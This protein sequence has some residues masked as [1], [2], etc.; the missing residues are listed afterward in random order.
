[1]NAIRCILTTHL[2][3]AIECAQIDLYFAQAELN[4]VRADNMQ[5]ALMHMERAANALTSAVR[6]RLERLDSAESDK[7][8]EDR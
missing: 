5:A 3:A 6:A 4:D 2:Q 8:D 7:P 1:M